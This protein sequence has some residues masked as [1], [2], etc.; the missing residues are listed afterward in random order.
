M[1]LLISLDYPLVM[2][3]LVRTTTIFR[4]QSCFLSF[5]A[6]ST[7]RGCTTNRYHTSRDID[8]T[9]KH[10]AI[11]GGGITGLASAYYASHRYPS[12]KIVLYEASDRLGGVIDSRN[13]ML[14]NGKNIL[15]EMGPRTL[16]A[17]A[18]RAIVTLDLVCT[19]PSSHFR[20][21]A[22]LLALALL[23]RNRCS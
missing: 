16:R 20:T 22:A 23:R 2:K 5:T 21:S 1:L 11:I 19:G 15:C 18:P 8:H 7:S 14:E 3:Y 17:N 6:H 4:L 13:I 10:I 12:A 9:T